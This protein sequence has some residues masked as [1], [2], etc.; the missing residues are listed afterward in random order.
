MK[1]IQLKKNTNFGMVDPKTTIQDQRQHREPSATYSVVIH[2]V[3]LGITDAEISNH[4]NANHLEHRYC[5]RIVSKATDQPTRIIRVITGNVATFEHLLANGIYYRFR[6]YAVEP[7]R[8]PTP[9]PIPCGKCSQFTH[10]TQ[11]CT[12]PTKCLKC[13]AAHATG[14]CTTELPVKCGTCKSEGYVAWSTKCPRRPIQ[15]I[16]GIPNI[17]ITT[18][19]KKSNDVDRTVKDKHSR[20]HSPITLHDIIVNTYT[21][22]INKPTNNN[23]EELLKKLKQ[24]S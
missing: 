12:T 17:K 23:R 7:S 22:K 13:G 1:L 16:A 3:E 9:L 15:P 8:P 21:S 6:H 20:I 10:I 11:N 18:V 4:L 2:G 14:R 24:N 19:N 5:K